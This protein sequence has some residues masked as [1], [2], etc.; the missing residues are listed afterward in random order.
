M[1][2]YKKIFIAGANGMLGTTLQ[3]IV[4]TKDFL[5]TDKETSKNISWC[6]IRDLKYTTNLIKEYQYD[7]IVDLGPG[8]S[9]S[10]ILGA[11]GASFTA[12]LTSASHY[13]SLNG[14]LQSFQQLI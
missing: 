10:K 9:M 13:R 7:L 6:D 8:D 2:Q 4:D 1:K 5:L 3:N 12:A 11:S 14:F